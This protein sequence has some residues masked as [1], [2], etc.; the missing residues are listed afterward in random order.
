LQSRG[1][2]E[3]HRNDEFVEEKDV[4]GI[5]F[6]GG[7][8]TPGRLLG[9]SLHLSIGGKLKGER[10][11]WRGKAQETLLKSTTCVKH[12]PV[13]AASSKTDF[14][15]EKNLILSEPWWREGREEKERIN[16]KS[17]HDHI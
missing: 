11:G 6:S 2:E 16:G 1:K 14:S 10:R 4:G 9:K 7:R 5:F 17:R 3:G 12:R 15:P 8:F 13:T